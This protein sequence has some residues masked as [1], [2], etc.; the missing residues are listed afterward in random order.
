VRY[1]EAPGLIRTAPFLRTLERTEQMV[2]LPL[3]SIARRWA[4]EE[5]P[6]FRPVWRRLPGYPGSAGVSSI[7]SGP[8]PAAFD[9]PGPVEGGARI[10]S[11]ATPLLAGRSLPAAPVSDLASGLPRDPGSEPPAQ[12]PASVPVVSVRQDRSRAAVGAPFRLPPGVSLR[13]AP[14][15]AAPPPDRTERGSSEPE[16]HP[17]AEVEHSVPSASSEAAPPPKP[18]SPLP[19][20]AISSSPGPTIQRSIQNDSTLQVPVTPATPATLATPAAAEPALP[21]VRVDA[22][23]RPVDPSN[24]VHSGSRPV[25][26]VGPS[27]LVQR[28]VRPGPRPASAAEPPDAR[29]FHNA[30]EFVVH[31]DPEPQ[32]NSLFNHR[33]PTLTLG[34]TIQR[35]V[36]TRSDTPDGSTSSAP[37][38]PI[39]IGAPVAP[40]QPPAELDVTRVADQV[41]SLLVDRLASERDRRGY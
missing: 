17:P 37:N 5:A 28:A 31:A 22:P 1:A 35:A 23:A 2:R 21:L 8:S 19:P 9:L 38:V 16:S 15:A 30:Q 20:L 14:S 32:S 3:L 39:P 10:V 13:G 26:P 18:R 40:A 27:V 34:P 11:D 33:S 36:D 7:V 25:S 24:P 41:Y 4:P 12:E 6:P 29:P